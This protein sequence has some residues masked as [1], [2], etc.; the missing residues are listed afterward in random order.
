MEALQGMS[1]TLLKEPDKQAFSDSA[2]KPSS[3]H[4][5]KNK[6]TVGIFWEGAKKSDYSVH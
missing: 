3:P 2:L 5:K 6:I 4:S 1:T